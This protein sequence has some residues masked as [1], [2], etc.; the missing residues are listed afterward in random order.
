MRILVVNWRDLRNPEAGGAEVHLHEIFGRLARRGHQVTLLAHAFAGAPDREVL[1]D[2][3]VRR[4]GGKYNFNHKVRGFLRHFLQEERFDVLVEDLNKLPFYLH[5][6][7]DTPSGVIVHHFFGASLFREANPLA[8]A[9]VNLHEWLV[10]RRYRHLPMNV[11]SRSTADD[12]LA[13]GFPRENIR[14]IHNAVDHQL[15]KPDPTRP[16]VPGRLLY[17]GRVK[18]YKGIDYVIRALPLVRQSVPEAHLIVAGR[19]D[20]IPRLKRCVKKL[21]LDEAVQFTGFVSD[22]EKLAHLQRA[23]V[24]VTPSEKEG[25]GV[26]TIEANACGTPVVA[27]DV[28]GLRDSIRHEETGLLFPY[29]NVPALRDALVRILADSDYRQSLAGAALAWA[30][31]FQ[32]ETS[33][34]E[35]EAWLEDVI[36][37]GKQ[38]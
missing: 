16:P 27:S 8:A 22:P 17:L 21:E 37:R 30:D 26:T 12:L 23:T 3:N 32:W 25:W 36:R 6:L 38:R 14:I 1:D 11:V 5:R 24:V 31:K 10:K 29:G 18:R 7:D 9:Y 34:Q 2:M 15:L 35:T 13:H 28:P 20:D 4:L 33:A 19:G